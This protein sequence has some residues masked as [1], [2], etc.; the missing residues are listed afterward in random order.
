VAER[1]RVELARAGARTFI[2]ASRT[3]RPIVRLARL[4]EPRQLWRAF[5]PISC[6]IDPLTTIPVAAPPVLV[7]AVCALN[8]ASNSASKAATTTGK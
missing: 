1:R 5:M 8:E 2:A 7:S 3:A 4:P 6:A